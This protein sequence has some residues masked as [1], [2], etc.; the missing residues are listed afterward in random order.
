MTMTENGSIEKHTYR[1]QALVA[2]NP[3]DYSLLLS[4]NQPIT[5]RSRLIIVIYVMVSTN[6]VMGVH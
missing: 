1:D 5:Q 6:H 3:E 2:L 4:T